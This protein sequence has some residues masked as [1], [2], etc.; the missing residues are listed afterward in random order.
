[1]TF[2]NLSPNTAQMRLCRRVLGVFTNY[3]VE[4][5]ADERSIEEVV[6]K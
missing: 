2:C 4:E 3:R 5:L 6:I 1:M